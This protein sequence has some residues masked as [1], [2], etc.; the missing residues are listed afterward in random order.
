V[1]ISGLPTGYGYRVL[2]FGCTKFRPLPKKGVVNLKEFKFLAFI[3][4]LY[5]VSLAL[6]CWIGCGYRAVTAAV[7]VTLAQF[8]FP[9]TVAPTALKALLRYR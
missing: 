5:S 9:A 8:E 3:A 7:D 2:S 1:D 4:G 6:S